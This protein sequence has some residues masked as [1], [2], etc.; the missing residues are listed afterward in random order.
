MLGL[1]D[2]EPVVS[3]SVM[4]RLEALGTLE[5]VYSAAV[6]LT[7]DEA[8]LLQKA[9]DFRRRFRLAIERSIVLLDLDDDGVADTRRCFGVTEMVRV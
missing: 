9:N 5:H 2:D 4:A 7:G 8:L 6:T 1:G 3:L